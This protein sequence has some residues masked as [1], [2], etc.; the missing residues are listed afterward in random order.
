[1]KK[2]E[3]KKELILS[4]VKHLDPNISHWLGCF[5]SISSEIK[6]C[7]LKTAVYD[8]LKPK[9]AIEGMIISQMMAIHELTMLG[10]S[11][12]NIEFK[13]ASVKHPAFM[14]VTAKLSNAFCK[15]AE[16]LKD[17]RGRQTTQHIKVEQV[18]VESGA[19]AIVGNVSTGVKSDPEK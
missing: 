12:A 19:N 11:R 1:M 15:L 5:D 18:K 10:M 14:Q 7:K 8:D 4:E 6:T 17:Y 16:T 3:P 2:T 13:T 9:D